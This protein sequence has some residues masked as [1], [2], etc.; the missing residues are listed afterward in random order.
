MQACAA[1][2]AGA[3]LISP[4][5]GRIMDWYK[6]KEGREFQPAGGPRR[7]ERA[8]DL[9]LLQGAEVPDHRHGRLLP[10]HRARSASWPGMLQRHHACTQMLP[11]LVLQISWDS[12]QP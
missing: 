3:A 4:F 2:D 9:P 1:A 6:K 8:E 10:Q 12:V 11:A 5:V 7:E